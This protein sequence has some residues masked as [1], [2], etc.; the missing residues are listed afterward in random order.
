MDEHECKKI[1]EESES[2]RQA[3]DPKY[4]VGISYYSSH[5]VWGLNVY[6]HPTIIISYCP[7]CGSKL[8]SK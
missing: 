5:K 4:Y 6:K 1:K 2:L 8:T 3:V 7:F